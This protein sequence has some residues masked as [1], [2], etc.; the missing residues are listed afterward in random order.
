MVGTFL[1]GAG[2]MSYWLEMTSFWFVMT[3]VGGWGGY[4][5]SAKNVTYVGHVGQ[6]VDT[7]DPVVFG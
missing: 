6:A 1:V 5:V 3:Y 2:D 7:V 4:F